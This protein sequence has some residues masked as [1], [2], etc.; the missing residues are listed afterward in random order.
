MMELEALQ[1]VL[2]SGVHAAALSR[3]ALPVIR[4][5]AW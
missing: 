3:G 1:A 4:Q 5:N 2:R